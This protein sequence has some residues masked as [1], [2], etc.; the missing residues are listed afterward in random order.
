MGDN[1]ILQ[2]LM[3]IDMLPTFPEIAGEMV[4]L[5]ED[6]KTSASD[7]AQRMDP[8]MVGEVLRIANTAY[9]GTKSFR[10]I[11]S[12]EHAIAVI[13]FEQLLTIILQMPFI[14][15]TQGDGGAF[16][17]D[18]F[19][20]HSIIC[21]LIAKGISKQL[22]VGNPNE[23]YLS[24]I[25]H[26]VGVIIIYRYFKDEWDAIDRL[27]SSS[28]MTR[29][30]AERE[31]LL[32]DHGH[33]GATLLELWNTP[34]PI[35]DAVRFHHQPEL[36]TENKENVLVTHLAN[37]L[38]KTIDLKEDLASFDGFIA[39]H[40]SSIQPEAVMGRGLSLS[41]EVTFFETIYELLRKAKVYVDGGTKENDDEST[42]S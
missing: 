40:R 20:T 36:A 42:C 11:T 23:V 28:G 22:N 18:A 13:G 37:R 10:N 6:P 5:I 24:G 41:E 29:I 32:V 34:K 14:S 30:E 21:G 33:M 26:D 2:K 25:M 12:L 8:S 7:L 35:T 3:E 39:K 4:G 17:K 1:Y 9:A 27:V 15:M 19:V 31:V 38:A 16:K